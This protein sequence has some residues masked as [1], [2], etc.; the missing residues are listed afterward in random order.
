MVTLVSRGSEIKYTIMQYHVDTPLEEE[1]ESSPCNRVLGYVT[2]DENTHERK[3]WNV[4]ESNGSTL[5]FSLSILNELPYRHEKG[6]WIIYRGTPEKTRLAFNKIVSKYAHSSHIYEWDT[7]R[8]DGMLVAV[9]TS[10][11]SY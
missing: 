3:F 11:E 1:L 7:W 10:W 5:H 6:P 9:V 4:G 8:V 2:E